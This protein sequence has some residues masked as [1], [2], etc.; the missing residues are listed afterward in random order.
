MQYAAW[1][2]AHG[3]ADRAVELLTALA[4]SDPTPDLAIMLA[5]MRARRGAAVDREVA[6]SMLMGMLPRLP[7]LDRVVRAESL[8]L[9]VD[10]L[11][12][13]GRHA[14]AQLVADGLPKDLIPIESRLA[15]RAVVEQSAGR[16]AEAE[17]NAHSALQAMNGDTAVEDRRRLA[18]LVRRLGWRDEALRLWKTIVLRTHLTPDSHDLLGCAQECGDDAFIVDF[19]RELRTHGALDPVCFELELATLQRYHDTQDAMRLMQ[20]Y[21]EAPTDHTLAA[22][23]RVRLALVA[24]GVGRTDIVSQVVPELPAATEVGAALGRAV[25]EVL[26]LGPAPEEAMRYAYELWRRHPVEFAAY[27][28]VIYAANLGEGQQPA[29]EAPSRV[30]V[31]SAARYREDDT[32]AERSWVIEERPDRRP[33]LSE[34]GPDH[35]LGCALLGKVVHDQFVLPGTPYHARTATVTEVMT[36]YVYRWRERVA[37]SQELFPAQVHMQ[38]VPVSSGPDAAIDIAPIVQIAQ[39]K[40]ETAERVAEIYR[41]E[42][43]PLFLFARR[44][45]I[46]VIDAVL[47]IAAHPDLPLRC[48]Q[49]GGQELVDALGALRA[50][51]A[52]V[53][54]ASA[55]GTLLAL[56]EIAL[57]R[58]APIPCTVAAGTLEEVRQ[59]LR[60]ASLRASGG[61][62][63]AGDSIAF[64][65]AEPTEQAAWESRLRRALESIESSCQIE[66]GMP[67]ARLG[68]EDREQLVN[69]FGQAGAE[70]MVLASQP[71]RLLWTDD[72]VAAAMTRQRLRGRS[73][74]TY[75]VL[76]HLGE[77][78][79]LDGQRLTRATLRLLIAGH[80]SVLLSHSDIRQA[81]VDAD[82]QLDRTPLKQ[83]P[84]WFGTPLLTSEGIFQVACQS[85]RMIWQRQPHDERT[86]SVTLRLLNR[87]GSRSQGVQILIALQNVAGTIFG[88]DVV[89]AQRVEE[90]IQAWLATGQRRQILIP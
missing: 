55:I 49:G 65:P 57:L 72:W 9:I 37:R 16:V 4:E 67:L 40:R 39:R 51:S 33:E 52:L 89:A 14:E 12:A 17:A 83:A 15:L 8:D 32:G 62:V 85:F 7:E 21:L 34:I 43:L 82:W 3:Q 59:L 76:A 35:P 2:Y 45:G 60:Q 79:A 44:L 80:N 61:G 86:D 22:R 5:K 78:G 75:P 10:H 28:A 50:A 66:G 68:R 31:G 38:T 27:E 24:L 70:A 81:L 77:S 1:L 56:D 29:I 11:C 58:D 71:G 13:E 53:L 54:D 47:G 42:T 36:K 69:A 87:I 84:D 6:L 26:R 90:L 74:C 64:I 88:V 48:C 20:E 19:C 46:S 63:A 18:R 41:R 30:E 73:T 25:V 23:T